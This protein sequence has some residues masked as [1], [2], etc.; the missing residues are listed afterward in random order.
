[1][2]CTKE[3]IRYNSAFY[4]VVSTHDYAV[5]LVTSESDFLNKPLPG[6][7][8]FPVV[9][10]FLH[11]STEVDDRDRYASTSNPEN[12]KL[13]EAWVNI[14]TSIQTDIKSSD[15]FERLENADCIKAY[16]EVLNPTRRNLVIVTANTTTDVNTSIL[17][18]ANYQWSYYAAPIQKWFSPYLWSVR[19]RTF[20]IRR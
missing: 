12:W 3:A 14:T 2:K 19:S 8:D 5:Y 17:A 4:S 7:G 1:M 15:R 16:A 10:P 9:V 18:I 13:A 6:Y 11:Y 20:V